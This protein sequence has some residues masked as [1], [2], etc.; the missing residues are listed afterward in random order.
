MSNI[1]V[2]EMPLYVKRRSDRH[3]QVGLYVADRMVE[4]I[5]LKVTVMR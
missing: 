4:K 2:S 1:A 5:L 3:E